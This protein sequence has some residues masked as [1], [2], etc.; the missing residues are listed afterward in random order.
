MCVPVLTKKGNTFLSKCGDSVN[1]SIGLKDWIANN[2]ED[3]VLKAV[4]F[5]K[6][7]IKIQEVKN[8]L[9]NNRSNFKLFDGKDF[10]DQLSNSFKKMLQL[11]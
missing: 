1:T 2:D 8:Y 5:A 10:A 9:K 7:F 11:I 3:Y 6:D 4:N